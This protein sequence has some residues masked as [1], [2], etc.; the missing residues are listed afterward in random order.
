MEQDL[1]F[2]ETDFEMHG[3]KLTTVGPEFDAVDHLA[4]AP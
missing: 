1:K 2:N 4:T 3:F